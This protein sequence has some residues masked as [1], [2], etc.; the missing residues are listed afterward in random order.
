MGVHPVVQHADQPSQGLKWIHSKTYLLLAQEVFQ[1][2]FFPLLFT[3]CEFLHQTS[4]GNVG[5]GGRGAQLAVFIHNQKRTYHWAAY[6]TCRETFGY[7]CVCVCVL[8]KPG[9]K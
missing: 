4:G 7:V 8:F 9:I 6:H 3:E 5:S 1:Y 2:N